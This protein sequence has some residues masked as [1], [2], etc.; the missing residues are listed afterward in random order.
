MALTPCS[1]VSA[2]DWVMAGDR[3]WHELVGFGP[4]GFPAYARLLFLPDQPWF[5]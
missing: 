3:P 4:Q 5:R 2:A 1:D